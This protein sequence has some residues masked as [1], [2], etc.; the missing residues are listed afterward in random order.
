[1][2]KG[3]GTKTMMGRKQLLIDCHWQCIGGGRVHGRYCVVRCRLFVF[4]V[5]YKNQREPLARF[6]SPLIFLLFFIIF[7]LFSYS[8][9]TCTC[10]RLQF[11]I[12]LFIHLFIRRRPRVLAV[13]SLYGFIDF[14]IPIF[15]SIWSVAGHCYSI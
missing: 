14:L 5:M 9:V 3:A 6:W 15:Y 1:M 10:C 2:G 13:C 11:F 8:N 12:Y 4:Y 7:F